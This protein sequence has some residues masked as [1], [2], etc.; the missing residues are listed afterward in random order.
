M[1][2]GYAQASRENPCHPIRLR[3]EREFE[4]MSFSDDPLEPQEAGPSEPPKSEEPS[5]PEETILPE[6]FTPLVESAHVQRS[7]RRQARRQIA[8]P[9][10]SD[11]AAFL[12]TL[13][14][15]ATPSFDFFLFALISGAVLGAGYLLDLRWNSMAIFLLGLL[16]APLLTP[17]VGLILAVSTGS[18]RFFF[19][20]IGGLIVAC[21]LVFLGS[22]LAGLAGRLWLPFPAGFQPQVIIR[23]HI[24]WLDL[25]IVDLG[26]MVLVISFLRSEEKPSLPSL[27]VAYG[28]FMPLSAAGFGWGI[29]E[30]SIWQNGVQVFL[31][32]L[33]LAVIMGGL[34]L[35]ALRFKP[36]R[37]GG[38]VLSFTGTILSIAAVVS[39]TGAVDAIRSGIMETHKTVPTPT[40]VVLPSA[41]PTKS[42]RLPT[43][44]ITVTITDTAIPTDTLTPTP[45]YAIIRS[46]SGGGANVRTEPGG[47]ALIVTLINGTLVQ[48]LPETQ[49]VRSSVW[50]KVRL[51]NNVQGWVLQ[52]VLVATE[53]TPI[54]TETFTP[55][56]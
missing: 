31:L 12:E 19:L 39:F 43:P 25:F 54:P 56:P 23:S 20:M 51:P 30:P 6:G 44:T 33:A 45:A 40:L 35:S 13:S 34:I 14:R 10:G 11:R 47:G 53:Q 32:H 52:T 50:V 49:T 41:T 28:L 8:M 16:L 26:A 27:M 7:R 42:P 37:V 46:S 2:P 22:S 15:R 38:Y 48:V 55:T 4:N 36:H 5:Y 1:A 17:M 9:D 3:D 29:G 21:G 24:W 18:W